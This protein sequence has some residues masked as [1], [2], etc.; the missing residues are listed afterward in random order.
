MDNPYDYYPEDHDANSSSSSCTEENAKWVTLE[1]EPLRPIDVAIEACKERYQREARYYKW[2]AATREIHLHFMIM[3]AQ[4]KNFTTQL[5]YNPM[6]VCTCPPNQIHTRII[7]LIDL[8]ACFGPRPINTSDYPASTQDRLVI[9]LDGNFQHCHHIKASSEYE[10]LRVPRIFIHQDKV[11]EMSSII[12]ADP[13]SVTPTQPDQCTKSHKAADD[14]HNASTWKGCDDTGLMGCCCRHDSVI[15]MANIYK[16]GEKRSLPLALLQ[17]VF[18][19]IEP[20]RQVGILYDIGC[21]LEKFCRLGRNYTKRFFKKQWI[22]QK[23][24]RDQQKAPEEDCR[25][26]LV[27][28]YEKEAT[29]KVSRKCLRGPQAILLKDDEMSELAETIRQGDEEID[30][31]KKELARKDGVPIDDEEQ[32]LLLLLW[33]AKNKLFVQATH[34]RA[35]KQLLINSQT[36]GSRLGTR[37]K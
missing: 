26:K 5:N 23:K 8:F 20:E 31:Q 24:L 34:M 17:K 33:N 21:S 3:K 6:P 16:S 10:I 9:C 12:D 37:G 32:R 18:S 27:T 11:E 15:Y 2:D 30:Q 14:Q 25:I 22:A 19:S 36:I 4:T 28:L 13:A 29:V 1:T 7:D 35:E